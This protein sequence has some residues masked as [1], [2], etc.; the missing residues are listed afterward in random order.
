MPVLVKTFLPEFVS[1]GF[2]FSFLAVLAAQ[3]EHPTPVLTMAVALSVWTVSAVY[4]GQVGMFGGGRKPEA[5]L[6][7]LPIT[8]REIVAAKFLTA[9]I[10]VAFWWAVMVVL[11]TSLELPAADFHTLLK[12]VSLMSVPAL[13]L[14]AICYIGTA[15]LRGIWMVA[16]IVMFGVSLMSG[17]VVFLVKAEQA[18]DLFEAPFV[19]TAA[20]LSWLNSVLLI[21][22]GLLAYRGLMNVA[23]RAMKMNEGR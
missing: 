22:L 7:T 6:R 3:K 23:V 9:L 19:S 21:A 20:G 11:A 18:A 5:F 10:F 13:L 8:I 1:H 4:F 16:L 12:F 2:T 14:S 15:Y 17:L